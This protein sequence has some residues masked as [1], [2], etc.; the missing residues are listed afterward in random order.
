MPNAA[1]A[2]LPALGLVFAGASALSLSVV[3]TA[4]R[5]A[6]DGG[7]DAPTLIASRAAVGFACAA[8]IALV[9]RHRPRVSAADGG[10]LLGMSA[11][12]L[13]IN[14]GYMIS[15]LYIP[16][17]LAALIFYIFPVLVLVV[18]AVSGRRFPPAP[19]IFAFLTAFAGLGMAL[20]PSF[21]ALDGR[22]LAAALVATLGGTLLMLFGSR[23]A[24][25]VGTLSTLFFMQAIAACVTV[26]VMLGFDG[27]VPPGTEAGWLAL[28]AACTGYVIGVG[29]QVVAVKLVDPAPAS[30][31]YNL[32]PLG[33]LAIAA[34]VLSERLSPLQYLGGAMVLGAIV[35]AS[36]HWTRRF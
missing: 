34:L 36:R 33:T 2:T 10:V 11:G 21:A 18:D 26:S 14:F 3:T 28:G 23:A 35:F 7:I 15:V 22:G 12:Q 5:L 30:L 13:M 9:L 1:P 19:V 24:R 16:V 4:A 20:A 29:L 27:P 8:L 17:S 32:E 6:Y 25:R 31:V